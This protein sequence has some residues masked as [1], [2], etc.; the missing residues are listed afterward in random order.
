MNEVVYKFIGKSQPETQ[1]EK[2]FKEVFLPEGQKGDGTR[3]EGFALA[4]MRGDRTVVGDM[5]RHA[6]VGTDRCSRIRQGN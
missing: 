1:N 4:L 6:G 3:A 2:M 5:K